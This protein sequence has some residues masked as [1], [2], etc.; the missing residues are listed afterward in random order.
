MIPPEES[1]FRKSSAYKFSKVFGPLTNQKRLFEEV[2]LPMLPGVL[3]RD[4]FNGLIFEYGTSNSGNSH[5]V[6]GAGHCFNGS[7]LPQALAVLFKS[8]SQ[9]SQDSGEAAHYRP[10]GYRDIERIDPAGLVHHNGVIIDKEHKA[11]LGVIEALDASLG[12]IAKNLKISS[13]RL[14]ETSLPFEKFVED[15]QV[16]ELPQGM[17]YTVWL[18]C[19]EIYADKIYDLLAAPSE[20][21]DCARTKPTTPKRPALFLKNDLSTGYKY[22][23]GL[24]EIKVKTMDEAFLVLR[25]GLK[26]RQVFLTLQNKTSSRSHCVVTIKVLKTPQFGSSAAEDAAKG[27][28]SLSRIS[29]VDLAGSERARN[30]NS[31]GQRLKEA[32]D[33][34]NSIMVLGHCMETL[35]M[36]QLQR[37]KSAPVPYHLSK[38]TQLFQSN[39]EDRSENSQ[40]T[41]LVNV[42]PAG[43]TFDETTQILR[44]SSTAKDV[45]LPRLVGPKSEILTT[46][47][48][49]TDS[50][51]PFNSISTSSKAADNTGS[52]EVNETNDRGIKYEA[53]TYSHEQQSLELQTPLQEMELLSF[54]EQE[55]VS[56]RE[57]FEQE[58]ASFQQMRNEYYA[59]QA[60]EAELRAAQAVKIAEERE[61]QLE[62]ETAMKTFT[63]DLIQDLDAAHKRIKELVP[64]EITVM[65]LLPLKEEVETLRPLKGQLEV[66]KSLE[67][68][69]VYHQMICV[70]VEELRPLRE[71]VKE[72][73]QLS[74]E[75]EMLRGELE[76]LQAKTKVQQK[77]IEELLPL[78]ELS[79]SLQERLR[80]SE[81]QVNTL[82]PLQ[83]QVKEVMSIRDQKIIEVDALR[84]KMKEL[85]ERVKYLE[86]LQGQL[87]DMERFRDQVKCLEAELESRREQSIEMASLREQ[88]I[89][90]E[91]LRVQVADLQTR[92]AEQELVLKAKMSASTAQQHDTI[93]A[94]PVDVVN[95]STDILDSA[96]SGKLISHSPIDAAPELEKSTRELEA[97]L[98]EKDAQNRL[99]QKQYDD[100]LARWRSWLSSAPVDVRALVKSTAHGRPLEH[101]PFLNQRSTPVGSD[102]DTE[103]TKDRRPA[104]LTSGA[105]ARADMVFVANADGSDDAM[106]RESHV[107]STLNTQVEHTQTRLPPA[108]RIIDEGRTA[109]FDSMPLRQTAIYIEVP[110]LQ[111][112]CV[113]EALPGVKRPI[114][115]ERHASEEISNS[116]VFSK[117][118]SDYGSPLVKR[119]RM[120]I[121]STIEDGKHVEEIEDRGKVQETMNDDEKLESDANIQVEL[122][123]E[124][125][126]SFETTDEVG[127]VVDFD[128][129]DY[130]PDAD[131]IDDEPIPN[132]KDTY[133]GRSASPTYPQVGIQDSLD[134]DELAH[135]VKRSASVDQY[136]TMSAVENDV[137]S[138][139]ELAQVISLYPKLSTL[140][141]TPAEQEMSFQYPML[142]D[143]KSEVGPI[144]AQP[145]HEF[146][147]ES[148][149][150]SRVPIALSDDD[151]LGDD[152]ICQWTPMKSPA[153]PVSERRSSRLAQEPVTMK[154][155]DIST[156]AVATWS[157][158]GTSYD[159]PLDEAR[160]KA[161]DKTHEEAHDEAHREAHVED[162]YVAA[163]AGT[164][165]IS[166]ETE[167]PKRPRRRLRATKAVMAEEIEECLDMP[168]PTSPAK[169]RRGGTGG[170]GRR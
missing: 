154:T 78:R 22:V 77:E 55:L 72:L 131:V 21:L 164:D 123:T 68:K 104:L 147:P 122:T 151:D 11:Q 159:E 75:V 69:L 41:I 24:N 157:S 29:I 113:S 47:Q 163:S 80:I 149:F 13:G 1:N 46:V 73:R 88:A 3:L 118:D 156:D 51:K 36:N 160:D 148:S 168:P 35:R 76:M 142:D 50:P 125:D 169:K 2:C 32:G 150:Y 146:E 95:A 105:E 10:V 8:I 17:D 42:N 60:L 98:A 162:E 65:E 134:D 56:R 166:T 153:K 145:T 127:T 97:A 143:H 43:A 129:S 16:I 112:R 106:D 130:M 155:E 90:L 44:F 92:L 31:T 37:T 27:K 158:R 133:S 115:S 167:K 119:R 132:R 109:E 23:H 116:S 20:P 81:E 121:F 141:P 6:L 59:S 124:V 19:S 49:P 15:A 54:R 61:A 30:T 140:S 120:S 138:D 111:K 48:N 58:V 139:K 96:V 40:V 18:S 170:S 4:N 14:H 12:K 82:A 135:P 89:E 66:I 5:S 7:I 83:T 99:I 91:P 28:T 126:R 63:R 9:Y 38:L 161:H 85:Q 62:R 100:T 33:I 45:T 102:V 152:D 136:E 117:D 108:A 25:A 110:M 74:E 64:L 93:I 39:F 101:V 103:P 128:D 94:T 79:S 53:D 107:I 52:M 114:A 57:K 87:A 70:E 84:G 144:L 67:E 165:A 34:N 26:Q 137:S 71:E 86:S